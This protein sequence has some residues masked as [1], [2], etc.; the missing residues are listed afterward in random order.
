MAAYTWFMENKDI[1]FGALFAL[2]EFLSFF[3]GVKSNGVFQLIWNALHKP[4]A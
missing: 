4:S 1:V 3:P 2:S